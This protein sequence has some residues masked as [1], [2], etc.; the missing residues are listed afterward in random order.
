MKM[1]GYRDLLRLGIKQD[2]STVSIIEEK[3]PKVIRRELSRE[4]NRT[5]SKVDEFNKFPCLLNFLLEQKRIIEYEPMS[6]RTGGAPIKGYASHLDEDGDYSN[7][8]KDEEAVQRKSQFQYWIHST[9]K[10]AIGECKVYLGK[11]PEDFEGKSCMLF[12]LKDQ[13]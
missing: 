2:T 1:P 5:N 4:V 8:I 10:H 6:L 7:A 12:M 3:L 13:A 11:Q 9:N